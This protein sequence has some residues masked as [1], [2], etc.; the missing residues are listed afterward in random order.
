MYIVVCI[1]VHKTVSEKIFMKML[2]MV[3]SGGRERS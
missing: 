1:H 2:T 3:I